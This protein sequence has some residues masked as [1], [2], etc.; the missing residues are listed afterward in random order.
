MDTL[1][2]ELP[3]IGEPESLRPRRR[4]LSAPGPGQALVRME[5]TGVSF[6][7]QQMRRG[8]YYDQPPFP[9]VPGYDLVGV[10]EAVGPPSSGD[11]PGGDGIRVGQRVAALTKTGAWAER[12][13]LDAGDLVRVPDGVDAVEAETVIVNGLTAWRMLHRSARVPAGGT[14]VVLGAAGGVGS[15]LTQLARHAGIRVIGVA[16]PRQ[17]AAV[18]ALGAIAIDHRAEDVAR[19]VRELAPGGVDAVFDHVGGPGIV[20]SWGMLAGG[21]TLVSYGTAAT[22]DDP[23][24]ARV[25]VLKLLARLWTWNLLPNGRSASFFNLWAGS[26]RRARFQ[27]RLREDLE[28]VLAL[29]AAGAV[30]PQVAGRFPLADAAGALRFAEAGGHAGKVV[31]VGE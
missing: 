1:Q 8:K 18:A 22:K 25:P 11:G 15:V 16:G 4:T 5:A 19:R 20:A 21:G 9:F 30:V 3:G 17:Q 6:A 28:H 26:R 29:V 23:G 13:V 10:V 7:E 2:I 24:N 12:V 14:I 31:I 27:H